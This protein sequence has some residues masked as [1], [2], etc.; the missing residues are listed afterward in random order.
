MLLSDD[1]FS[2]LED[3]VIITLPLDY[4][5]SVKALVF[6]GL[7]A[8][9]V[10]PMIDTLVIVQSLSPRAFCLYLIEIDNLVA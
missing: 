10:S 4:E 2:I 6:L 9:V 7:D 8:E 1:N 3:R 5:P